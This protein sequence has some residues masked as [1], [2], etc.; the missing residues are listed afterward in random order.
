M[1]LQRR[2]Q[3]KTEFTAY[4]SDQTVYSSHPGGVV[5]RFHCAQER[6]NREREVQ[7]SSVRL[8]HVSVNATDGRRTDGEN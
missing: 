8:K 4:T 5:P 7:R 1:C 6:R 2:L 3:Q